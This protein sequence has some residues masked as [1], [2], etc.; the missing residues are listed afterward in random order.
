MLHTDSTFRQV[1]STGKGGQ[2]MGITVLKRLASL[3]K[4]LQFELDCSEE[5]GVFDGLRMYA[6]VEQV[7]ELY[8][9]R[10]KAPILGQ[11]GLDRTVTTQPNP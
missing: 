9:P 7:L 8:S 2:S 1:V 10:A 11:Q 5:F 3:A 4:Q 6:A